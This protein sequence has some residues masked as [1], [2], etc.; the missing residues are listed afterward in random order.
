MLKN[1]DLNV[2]FLI[3][4]TNKTE[5]EE[6]LKLRL[7]FMKW[8]EEL[9]KFNKVPSV[10]EKTKVIKALEKFIFTID[11]MVNEVTGFDKYSSFKSN[12]AQQIIEKLKLLLKESATKLVEYA[13]SVEV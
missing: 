10:T 4:Q 2:L 6:V 3:T 9:K 13:K 8:A 5:S 11:F 1:C 7:Q 12:E